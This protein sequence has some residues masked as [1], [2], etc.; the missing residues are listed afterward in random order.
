MNVPHRNILSSAASVILH[1]HNDDDDDDDSELGDDEKED[2]DDDVNDDN[3]DV[4]DDDDADENSLPVWPLC[5]SFHHQCLD[6][7]T[8]Q[9][10]ENQPRHKCTI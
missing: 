9:G 2:D 5:N 4:N 8:L 10:F 3:D 6:P 7:S 1:L